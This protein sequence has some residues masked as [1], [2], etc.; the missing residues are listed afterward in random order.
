[1]KQLIKTVVVNIQVSDDH[2]RCH[3]QCPFINWITERGKCMCD[4]F[5][6]QI[7]DYLRLPE[8][9]NDSSLHPTLKDDNHER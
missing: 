7:I 4:L 5:Q 2:K 6:K 9:V 1:M 8:C 3:T